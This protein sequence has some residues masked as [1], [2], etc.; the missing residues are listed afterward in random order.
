MIVKCP[1]CKTEYNVDEA[2]IKPNG[3]K[4]KCFNCG[5][6]WHQEYKSETEIKELDNSNISENNFEAYNKNKKQKNKTSIVSKIAKT[7]KFLLLTFLIAFITIGSMLAYSYVVDKDQNLTPIERLKKFP[8]YFKT[9]NNKDFPVKIVVNRHF[10]LEYENSNEYIK[11][12]GKIVNPTDKKQNLPAVE[13]LLKNKAGNI[14]SK[15]EEELNYN[16]IK[17]YTDLPFVFKVLRISKDIIT[18]EVNFKK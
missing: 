17:P 2:V 16:Y 13:I 3:K 10:E 12:R 6:I 4:L 9:E 18:V 11:V 15:R 14:I 8:T 7:F 5:H 1:N